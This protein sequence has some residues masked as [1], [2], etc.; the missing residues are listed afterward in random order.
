MAINPCCVE[1]EDALHRA[2]QTSRLRTTLRG[3]DGGLWALALSRNGTRL[4]TVSM[5][6]TAK[7]WDP[8]TNQVLLTLPTNVTDNLGGTGA[9]FSP[10]GTQLLT[11]SS[12][13]NATLWELATGKALFLPCTA[14]PHR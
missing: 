6:G 4:A 7:V 3:H 10:D 11:I 13:N 5:D 1:A 14:T 12:D 2:V 8:A 9:T